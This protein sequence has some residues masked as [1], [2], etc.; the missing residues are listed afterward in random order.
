VRR[1]VLLAVALAGGCGF[2]PGPI[3]GSL[4]VTGDVVDFVTRMPVGATA[5][6]SVSG[7]A[8]TPLITTSGATFTLD[9]VKEHSTFQVLASAPPTHRA[10]FGPA[11]VVEDEPLT[12]VA[13]PAVSEAYLEILATGFGVTP[14]GNRGVL[15]VR[16]LDSGGAARAGVDATSIG[17][18][19]G[20]TVDGPYFLDVGL[21]P[22][23]TATA[24]TSSGWAVY[25]DVDPGITIMAAAGGANLT[26]DMPISPVNAGTVTIAEARVIDGVVQPPTNVSFEDQIVPIFE[27]RG[28]VGCHQGKREGA[29]LGD[30]KLDGSAAKIYDELMEDPTRVVVADP[31]RSLVLT[32][33]LREDPPDRHPNITFA[34]TLDP[35]WMLLEAWIVEGAQEN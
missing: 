27:D 31:D 34:N 32:M 35:D 15:F 4:T 17:V 28:C 14:A 6:V 26:V 1:T 12:G 24:T 2:D 10:T 25:F 8:W 16:L 30:L 29:E 3:G 20:P 11:I 9:D 13:V 21:Q 33:P 5:T 7:L 19:G 22:N 23:A 18:V